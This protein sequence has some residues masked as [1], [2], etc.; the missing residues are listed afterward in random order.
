MNSNHV[1][2][3]NVQTGT[4]NLS[5]GET[6]NTIKNPDEWKTGEEPLTGAQNS[7][8]HTLAS[9]AHEEVEEN[10]TKAEAS[11]KI[12]ELRHKTGRGVENG[13]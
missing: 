9:E 2:K 3:K 10:L 12:D 4:Q 13:Q 7:Y 1:Q 6:G 5:S 8:L 11:K